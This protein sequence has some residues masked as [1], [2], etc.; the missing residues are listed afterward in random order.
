MG[1][2]EGEREGLPPTRKKIK[3]KGIFISRVENGKIKETWE[4]ADLLSVYKQLGYE[5]KHKQEK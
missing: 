4:V 5:L 2:H 3:M 1:T